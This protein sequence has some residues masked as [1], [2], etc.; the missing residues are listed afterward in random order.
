MGVAVGLGRLWD[1]GSQS[2]ASSHI[3]FCLIAVWAIVPHRKAALKV[4]GMLYP[5]SLAERL[6]T[7]YAAAILPSTLRL[8][9]A[10]NSGEVKVDASAAHR[11]L[12]AT[13][14]EC[15]KPGGAAGQADGARQPQTCPA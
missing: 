13:R 12:P 10:P 2:K 15:E 11:P 6:T 8:C 14:L 1:F 7:L 9:E 3:T 5:L 4:L